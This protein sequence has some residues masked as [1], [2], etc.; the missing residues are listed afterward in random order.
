M[1]LFAF[2]DSGAPA[3]VAD[4]TTLVIL[5]GCAFNKSEHILLVL[6]IDITGMS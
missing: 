4:Y 5:H 2:D 1:S 3:D 6:R